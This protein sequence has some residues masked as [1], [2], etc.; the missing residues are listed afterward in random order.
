MIFAETNFHPSV[1]DGEFKRQLKLPAGYA[2]TGEVATNAKWARE[3]FAAHARP[4]LCAQPI[5]SCQVEENTVTIGGQVLTSG[6]LAKRFQSAESAVIVGVSTGSEAETEATSRWEED[7]PDRYYFMESY[8]TAVVETL[9]NEARHRLC[10][11]ASEQ[12]CVLLPHYSPGYHDWSVADQHKVHALLVQGG[13]I[14]GALEVMESGMLRP[15]NSQL[16]V[17]GVVA[18]SNAPREDTDMI[19]CKYCAQAP[20]ELRRE[21]C[22]LTE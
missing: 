19:P 10:Q 4:W 5:A 1:D 21:P 9:I 14:P 16:V 12:A 15:K 8:A 11:W 2:M 13:E 20:C 17:F 22:A 6:E 18:E 3:W 7:E